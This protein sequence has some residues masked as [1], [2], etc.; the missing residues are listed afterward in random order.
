MKLFRD[1]PF[2]LLAAIIATLMAATAIEKYEGT[3]Y[4]LDHIYG[5]PWFIALW[6]ALAVGA[7]AYIF[8]KRLQR[9]VWTLALHASLVIILAG[10]LASHLW[11]EQGHLHLRLGDD[12][13]AAFTGSDGGM[14]ALPFKVALEGFGITYY[15]GT[16]SPMDYTSTVRIDDGGQAVRGKVAMNEIMRHRHYRFYQSAYDSDLQGSTLAVSHDPWGIGLTYA[17][18]A[19]LLVSMAGFFFE[20]RSQFRALCSTL[21][22][23][24][25]RAAVF[26]ALLSL[27]AVAGAADIR[28]KALPAEVAEEFGRLYVYYG[29]RICPMETLARDFTTKLCGKS[30]YKGLTAEQV[31]TG[32]MFYYDY[33]KRE[34]MIEIKGGNVAAVLGIEGN[35]ASLTDFFTATNDYK[36]E[37]LLLGGL[38][39]TASKRLR[40]ADEKVNVASMA[41]TGSLIKIFPCRDP[42]DSTLLWLSQVDDIPAGTAHDQW[43]FIR[44]SLNYVNELIA[45]RQYDE[46]ANVLRK[47]RTYQEKEAAGCLPS[48]ACITAERIYNRTERPF[49]LGTVMI[50]VGIISFVAACMRMARGRTQGKTSAA[51]SLAMLCAALSWL[52]LTLGLRWLVSGHLPLSNGY[53]TMQF[54][55]WCTLVIAIIL[56][57]RSGLAATFGFTV[58]G[59]AVMV[60]MIG[61]T[62]PQITQLLPVLDSPLL[63]LHVVMVMVAYSLFAFMMLNG[64]AAVVLRFTAKGSQV[65]VCRLSL[66]SRVLLRP[67]VFTLAAG[68]FIGA[69]WANVSWGRYWGWDPKEVWA[70]I[71]L[72]IYTFALHDESLKA[73]RRPM[74]LHVF[75]ITAFASVVITYFGVNFILGGM[76]SYA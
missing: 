22:K 64:L 29:G 72:L 9:R 30:S 26:A 11:G 1:I 49:L 27:P 25:G 53:E 6:M 76:H 33:W 13:A 61:E 60:S 2:I 62:N 38:Q 66:V 21:R 52:T 20:K 57:R 36:L 56:R 24:A 10:S 59:M 14:V 65:A 23:G 31:V 74:F 16:R 47:I 51:I 63:S 45:K 8:R 37:G 55:A 40:E 50:T 12:G 34:P 28:D 41:A 68:I 15:P 39:D 35:R 46:V 7:V 69:V 71:T 18:Y 44:S 54:M 5:A 67:A 75:S 42:G 73:F 19:M 70:L 43:V 3:P 32:W 4:V 17:G 48:T 58:S